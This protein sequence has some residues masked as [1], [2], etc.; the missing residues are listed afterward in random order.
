MLIKTELK[1]MANF[2]TVCSWTQWLV[3][4]SSEPTF[5]ETRTFTYWVH[6]K[7]NRKYW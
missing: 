1:Q 4:P 6:T 5:T 3:K 2:I 7:N